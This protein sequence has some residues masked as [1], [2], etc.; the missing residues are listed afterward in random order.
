MVAS[1]ETR[2]QNYV[3]RTLRNE[4]RQAT[5]NEAENF[6]ANLLKTK[7]PELAY[8]IPKEF[9][10]PELFAVNQKE[11]KEARFQAIDDRNT[12]RRQGTWDPATGLITPQLFENDTLSWV[13]PKPLD[14]NGV[15]VVSTPKP[16]DSNVLADAAIYGA[17]TIGQLAAGPVGYSAVLGTGM[18]LGIGGYSIAQLLKMMGKRGSAL[19]IGKSLL[20]GNDSG[21]SMASENYSGYGPGF[22]AGDILQFF[23]P[24]SLEDNFGVGSANRRKRIRRMDPANAKAAMRASRRLSGTRKLL[25]KIEAGMPKV[26]SKTTNKG[27]CK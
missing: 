4:G 7:Y 5:R 24:A 12:I 21:G 6:V 22:D 27:C 13:A 25:R 26:K 15:P 20:T 14:A 9:G 16:E 1:W 17:T 8:L 3:N 23:L 2:I 19:G 10:G 18:A 11:T